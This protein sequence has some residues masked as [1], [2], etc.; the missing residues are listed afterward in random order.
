MKTLV[1]ISTPFLLLLV[2]AVGC[3]SGSKSAANESAAGSSASAGQTGERTL[4]VRLGGESA[5]KAVVDQF[6]SN[7]SA[8]TRINKFFANTNMDHFK[9]QLVNQIGQASG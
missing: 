7:V 5:I 1:R 8:D 2:M 9:T 4:Y 3:K 6:V